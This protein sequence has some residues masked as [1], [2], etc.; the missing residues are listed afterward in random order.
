LGSIEI[1]KRA[2]NGLTLLLVGMLAI[3]VVFPL[4]QMINPE[5]PYFPYASG[6]TTVDTSTTTTPLDFAFQ[7][8]VFQA[9]D[10]FW[11]FYS[12]GTEQVFKT[13][14]DNGT[15]WSAL[16]VVSSGRGLWQFS[17]WH[18]QGRN[19][20]YYV[21][22]SSCLCADNFQ[23]RNGTL[24]SDGT[25]AWNDIE[26]TE[27]FSG[28]T[29]RLGVYVMQNAFGDQHL[30][31]QINERR[32][33]DT[34]LSSSIFLRNITDAT[35]SRVYS[36][37]QLPGVLA[38]EVGFLV[39]TTAGHISVASRDTLTEIIHV[40]QSSDNFLTTD[41]AQDISGG[42][43]KQY[44]MDRSSGVARGNKLHFVGVDGSNFIQYW[45]MT[46]GDTNYVPN[47]INATASV[48]YSPSIGRMASS[49]L[50]INYNEN[51]TS[52]AIFQHL[53]TNNGDTF[54]FNNTI[55][56]G[57]VNP[58]ETHNIYSALTTSTGVIWVSEV[59]SPFNVRFLTSDVTGNFLNGEFD[60][61]TLS[62][63][64]ICDSI[65]FF[66]GDTVN[67]PLNVS[68][69]LGIE[70]LNSFSF[71]F[72][73]GFN[74]VTLN[75]NST[76]NTWNAVSG[77][78]VSGSV[79][80]DTA[81]TLGLGTRT[82]NTSTN[83]SIVTFP[84]NLRTGI[85]D[86]LDIDFTFQVFDSTFG[87]WS[88]WTPITIIGGFDV[89]IYNLG[90]QKE[91]NSI[92][93]GTGEVGL[94]T[95]GDT[96]EMFADANSTVAVNQTWSKFQAY[97][98][99]FN[100][101]ITEPDSGNRGE[102]EYWQT[103]DHNGLGM[104][105]SAGAGDWILRTNIWYCDRTT[106]VWV[107]GWQMNLSLL[108]GDHG[109]Q[110][111]WSRFN[112]TWS[113]NGV[114]VTS[115]DFYVFPEVE[116]SASVSLWHDLWFNQENASTVHGGRMNPFFWGVNATSF[117]LWTGTF[118]PIRGN[119]SETFYVNENEGSD[120]RRMSSRELGNSLM[121]IGFNLTRGVQ[122]GT[123]SGI[124]NWRL[125]VQQFDVS[126]VQTAFGR[127]QGVPTP[128][129]VPSLMPDVG[130]QGLFGGLF[131]IF[132]SL[133][134]FIV[135]AFLGLSNV[136]WTFLVS[137]IP[138]FTN[139]LTFGYNWIND[140]LNYLA[141]LGNL[142]RLLFSTVSPYIGFIQTGVDGISGTI[143]TISSIMAPIANN[144]QEWMFLFFIVFMILPMMEL[145]NRGKFDLVMDEL[146]MYWGFINAILGWF[147]RLAKMII[148]F[149]VN[150]IPL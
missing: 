114:N 105:K 146:R 103:P 63:N 76:A 28:F 150:I 13:S 93:S 73:D 144:A 100:L 14:D 65:Y 17:F 19:F 91:W 139:A 2:G 126:N 22:T 86:A 109:T 69:A 124:E 138:W 97:H 21:T 5:Y 117:L 49:S 47:V 50:I 137:Q 83:I 113:T 99:N 88:A 115:E 12:N 143:N 77:S 127:M 90:G 32:T 145:L 55:T 46:Y 52:G 133:G 112:A 23:W 96:F 42:S 45:N 34:R 3:A 66:V 59:S 44:N 40:V 102:D 36:N 71:Q 56:T 18:D 95:G 104:E 64:R 11:V 53:S 25:I 79:P 37:F 108:E 147:F 26:Q 74:N 142:M 131:A 87:V 149:F 16:T 98:T 116:S 29:Y 51:V 89:N 141:P 31:F 39:E 110:D 75:H 129:K 33:S 43:D 135:Q 94:I 80:V 70:R 9:H 78:L 130:S 60:L 15:T 118:Q 140:S 24:V 119:A 84:V 122:T 7:R 38:R 68:Y 48:S 106:Q 27:T 134:A 81:V 57:E 35:T 128:V 20:I 6:Q 1:K 82:V 136:I 121:K 10:L 123:G 62:P 85:Q 101:R 4:F 107:N 61:V 92:N 8:K 148:D 72:S 41:F 132:R 54:G 120:G 30:Y 58:I 125:H 67:F 111:Q